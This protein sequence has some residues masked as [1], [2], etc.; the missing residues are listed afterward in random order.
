MLNDVGISKRGTIITESKARLPPCQG[1][2]V[3]YKIGA[4]A[5]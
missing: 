1:P 2:L 3:V 4:N 5:R